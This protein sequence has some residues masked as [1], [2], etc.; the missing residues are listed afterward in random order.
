MLLMF[1][2]NLLLP[3]SSFNWFYLL[4][5]SDAASLQKLTVFVTS[6]AGFINSLIS[7]S[8]TCVLIS[9]N[10][11]VVSLLHSPFFSSLMFLLDYFS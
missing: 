3:N 8:L 1:W 4:V 9:C 11:M 10:V 2:L 6:F 7:L 5:V